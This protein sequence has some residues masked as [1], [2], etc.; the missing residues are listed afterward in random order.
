MQAETYRR[1]KK[2][3]KNNWSSFAPCTN[4]LW[5]HYLADICLTH[6]LPAGCSSG[7]KRELRNFRKR[8]LTY[9]C[10]AELLWDEFFLPQ[11]LVASSVTGWEGEDA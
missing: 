4:S 6:K 11:F 10:C 7:G 3:T 8:A 5:V 2:A 9:S 1:M